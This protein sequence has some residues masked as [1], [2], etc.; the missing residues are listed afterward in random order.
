VAPAVA[1]LCVHK[2]TVGLNENVEEMGAGQIAVRYSVVSNPRRAPYSAAI[3]TS[4][5]VAIK[6]Q[7]DWKS[8]ETHA[9]A[10]VYCWYR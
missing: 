1:Q 10:A 5:Y 8:I 9:Q 6:L 7:I 2:A 4:V 3:T